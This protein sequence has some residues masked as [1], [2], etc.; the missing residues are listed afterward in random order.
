MISNFVDK[1]ILHFTSSHCSMIENELANYYTKRV[2]LNTPN[3]AQNQ[4]NILLANLK[5]HMCHTLFKL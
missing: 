1:L 5:S 3:E 2:V 4:V